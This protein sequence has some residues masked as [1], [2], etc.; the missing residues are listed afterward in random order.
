MKPLKKILNSILKLIYEVKEDA[1]TNLGSAKN[2][3]VV[4]QHNQLGDVIVSTPL[5]SALKEKYPSCHVTVIAGPPNYKALE[6]NPHIDTMFIYDTHKLTNPAYLMSLRKIL[7]KEYD[8]TVVPTATSISFTSNFL[9]RLS[10]TGIRI[11]ALSLDGTVNPGSYLFNKRVTLDWREKPDTHASIRNLAILTPFGVNTKN[12]RPTIYSD[13]TDTNE[14]KK[15]LSTLPGSNNTPVI[16]M[17]VG[18]GKIPNRWPYLKFAEL[19]DRLSEKYDAKFYLTCG[20]EGDKILIDG[21]LKTAKANIGI[22]SPP[23][24]SFLKSLIDQ[25][26]LF[27]TNDTGPM[28][29]AAASDSPVISLFGP[30]NPHI[31]A[32]VG[33]NKLFIWKGGNIDSISVDDVF[34]AAVNHLN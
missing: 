3:L 9:A 22:I 10:N 31:W 2:I 32:P 18:A 27:I 16:G 6:K 20:S 4:R 11:G 1:G 19:I 23:G 21:I 30:Q 8:F 12:L 25:S 14:V 33:E 34:E 7:K 24:M 29:V 28:H 5:F 15:V 17:H 26:A 13:E